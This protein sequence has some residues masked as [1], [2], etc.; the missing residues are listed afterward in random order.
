MQ[1][2]QVAK[3]ARI[4]GGQPA[5]PDAGHAK[6]FRHAGQRHPLLVAVHRCW[7]PQLWRALQEPV[8]SVGWQAA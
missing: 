7:Q 5:Q 2:L 8:D 4:S 1:K 6:R 3:D